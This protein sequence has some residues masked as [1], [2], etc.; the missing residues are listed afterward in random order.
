MKT[1]K[2]KPKTKNKMA[3]RKKAQAAAYPAATLVK[4]VLFRPDRFQYVKEKTKSS[5]C[6]FCQAAK[7]PPAFET[8]CVYQSQHTMILLNKFPYNSGH[9]L[10]V[11]KEHK[12]HLLSFTDAQ[13][14]DLHATLK[15]ALT[16][17]ENLYQP[18]AIN[19][20]LNHGKAAGAGLPDHLH[21]HLIPRW[22]GDLN[23]FPIIAE[24]KAVVEAL[25]QTYKKLSDW[26]NT[27]F[28]E[29]EFL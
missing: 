9:L 26:F 14:Q 15:I 1:K 5:T 4:R 28:S 20:G 6:V 17:V 23:F 2:T 21:Y 11:P 18:A 19:I 27:E 12:G 3:A 8:L 13:Y 22:E 16:A 25:D 24:T 7:A 10:I 29:G